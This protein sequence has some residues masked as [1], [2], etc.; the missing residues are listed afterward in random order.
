MTKMGGWYDIN[1]FSLSQESLPPELEKE[2][3]QNFIAFGP[4]GN[5]TSL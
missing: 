5:I 4:E 3:G 1:P 2:A